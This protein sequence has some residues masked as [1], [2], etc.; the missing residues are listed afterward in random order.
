MLSET[1]LVVPDDLEESW[2]MKHTPL[3][4]RCIVIA[5]RNKTIAY[6][7][8]GYCL[9]VFHSGL[10]SGSPFNGYACIYIYIYS[11]IIIY[12]HIGVC[13]CIYIYIYIYTYFC[14]SP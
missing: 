12:I 13:M 11:Y 5:F 10:P 8:N 2:T 14:C 7:K 9:G 6:Q 1:M 4:K 3:G